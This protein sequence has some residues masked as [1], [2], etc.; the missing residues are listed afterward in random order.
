[1]RGIDRYRQSRSLAQKADIPKVGLGWQTDL[2]CIV[3]PSRGARLV[4]DS[5][6]DKTPIM[7]SCEIACSVAGRVGYKDSL[8]IEPTDIATCN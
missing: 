8:S 6:R 2:K 4:K 5:E 7:K 3:S 1:M